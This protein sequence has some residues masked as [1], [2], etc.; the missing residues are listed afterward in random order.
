MASS[1]APTKDALL[2]DLAELRT[3]LVPQRARDAKRITDEGRPFDALGWIAG[4]PDSRRYPAGPAFV[5]LGP[6]PKLTWAA[7]FANMG[8]SDVLTMAAG[9]GVAYAMGLANGARRRA[10]LRACGGGARR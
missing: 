7:A 4:A 5:P 10:A 2:A 1:D 6:L 3:H 9:A 8:V